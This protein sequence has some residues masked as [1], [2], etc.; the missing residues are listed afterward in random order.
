M[1]ILLA[2]DSPL[3]REN[4]EKLLRSTLADLEVLHS[5]GVQSTIDEIQLNHPDVVILDLRLIDGS[6]FQVLEYLRSTATSPATIVLTS[7]A[8]QAERERSLALGA[9]HFLDKST[10]YDR[11]IELLD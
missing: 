9:A 5:D 6:G 7:Y 1:K 4:L 2:D 11:L 10:D 3:V 8:G